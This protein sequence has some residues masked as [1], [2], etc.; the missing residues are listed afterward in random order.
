MAKCFF[1]LPLVGVVQF[2]DKGTHLVSENACCIQEALPRAAG[3]SG[4][5]RR[6]L[7]CPAPRSRRSRAWALASGLPC[8]ARGSCVGHRVLPRELWPV[9]KAFSIF[10]FLLW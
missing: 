7:L 8:H 3:A 5:A 4:K 2:P 6:R 1:P 9:I 10:F